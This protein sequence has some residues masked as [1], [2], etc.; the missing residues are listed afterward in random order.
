M[1]E[2]RPHTLLGWS[3]RKIRLARVSAEYAACR[4][5]DVQRSASPRLRQQIDFEAIQRSIQNAV[6]E[7]QRAFSTLAGLE[8][9]ERQNIARD[10]GSS[11]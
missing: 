2:T 6:Y 10:S 5:F 9:L 3:K 11:T 1:G 4:A 7:L 8:E